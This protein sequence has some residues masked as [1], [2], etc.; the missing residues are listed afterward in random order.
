MDLDLSYLKL[1]KNMPAKP[2]SQKAKKVK[3]SLF[4]ATLVLLITQAV[5][6]N[7]QSCVQDMY[8]SIP[9]ITKIC[10]EIQS[11]KTQNAIRYIKHL[12]MVLGKPI[13]YDCNGISQ[14]VLDR[15]IIKNE[16]K[17]LQACLQSCSK[18]YFLAKKV[19]NLIYQGDYQDAEKAANQVIITGIDEQKNCKNVTM[20]VL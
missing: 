14:D 16:K 2:K 4:T 19:T 6:Q 7:P 18:V 1:I 13:K 17:S 3:N 15:W 8:Y 11:M 10:K 20:R 12:I 9:T 5:T